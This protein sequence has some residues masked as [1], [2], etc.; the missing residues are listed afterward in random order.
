MTLSGV[1]TTRIDYALGM[2]PPGIGDN[3]AVIAPATAG[4]N[5]ALAF[6]RL[7]D[8]QTQYTSGMLVEAAGYLNSKTGKAITCVRS[9]TTTD[10]GYGSIDVTGVTGTSVVSNDATV[11]PIDEY[12]A[13]LIVRTGGTIG[14]AGIVFQS[15]LDN[16][17]TLSPLT[18][19][20]TANNFT[21]P[22]SGVKF[23]FAAGTLVAGDVVRVRTTPPR[24]GASD[25]TAAYEALR[26]TSLQWDVVLVA[27]TLDANGLSALESWLVT[28]STAKKPKYA[29]ANVRGPNVGEGFEAY[30][31]AAGAVVAN[32]SALY[33]SGWGGYTRTLSAVSA[34]KYR[35]PASWV[36]AA[37]CASA[38]LNSPGVSP[39]DVSLGPL[40]SDVQIMDDNGNPV[41]HNEELYPGLDAARLGSLRTR[42]GLTG[43]YIE[44]PRILAPVGSDYDSIQ[45][46]RVMNTMQ[47]VLE[48]YL[49]RRVQKGIR[50]NNTTGCIL[51]EEAIEIENGGNA[52]LEEALLRKPDAS[53]AYLVVNRLNNIL[54]SRQL[55][56]DGRCV[57][58]AYPNNIGLTLG[59]VN[60][61]NRVNPV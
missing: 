1:N 15:S 50:V 38:A 24:E 47:K 2:L 49:E 53:D 36:V 30:V 59:F 8:M 14:Q 37:R 4:L 6:G 25:L 10:G 48:P 35:R 23:A 13:Y 19:L 31:A 3:P 58:L 39:A 9:G 41:E 18:A 44:K 11:H 5:S 54:S 12:E 29:I 52:L 16:G 45:Y 28:M 22:G 7:A 20:G 60:P 17:R 21:I 32:T 46:V 57:P 27:N 34:R 43:V 51:D 55:L 26:V 61:A 42:A 56:C 33:T 40:F